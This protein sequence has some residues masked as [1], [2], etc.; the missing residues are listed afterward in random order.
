[1]KVDSSALDR[2]LRRVERSMDR[3]TKNLSQTINIDIKL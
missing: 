2:E 3:L 1:M